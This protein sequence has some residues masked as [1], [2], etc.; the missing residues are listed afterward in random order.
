MNA[1]TRRLRAVIG[2]GRAAIDFAIANHAL[3]GL[4][5]ALTA[6]AGALNRLCH[7]DT[8]VSIFCLVFH[9]VNVTLERVVDERCQ[10]NS[11]FFAARASAIILASISGLGG[12]T[13][14]EPVR[15]WSGYER[16]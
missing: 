6:F 9:K 8:S 15:E 12:R 5:H 7:D 1:Q 4:N 14:L 11:F 2:T 10:R 13:E 16:P 3:A